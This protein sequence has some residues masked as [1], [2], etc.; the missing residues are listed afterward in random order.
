MLDR[1]EPRRAVTH[2]RLIVVA[3]L[4]SL[5]VRLSPTVET[6]RQR[7]SAGFDPLQGSLARSEPQPIYG[8]DPEDAWNQV[9][10]LLFTRTISARVMADGAQVFAAG[11]ERLLLSNRRVARIES[12]DRAID[13]LYPSWLWMG[14][15]A[16]DFDHSTRWRI[17]R[18]PQYSRLVTALE[19][20]RRT[21]PSRPPLARALMQADL[22]SAYDMLH[23]VTQRRQGPS[24]ADQAE[25]RAR[26]KSLLLHIAKTIRALALSA[27]EIARLPDTYSAAAKRLRLPD[28][29]GTGTGWMEIRWFPHRSH[30]DAA[31]HR[32]ATRVFFRPAE[33][34]NDASAFLNSFRT[35]QGEN[36]RS[37]DSVALL[38]QLL[39][40]SRAGIVVPSPITYHVQF[41][42]SAARARGAVIPQYEL[43]RRQLL[44]S[45][46]SGGLV[47]IAANAP[48][49]LPIAG[50]DFS[51][52]TSRRLDAEAVIAPLEQRCAV[53]HGSP[54]GVGHLMTFAQHTSPDK[55]VPP[56]DRLVTAHNVHGGDVARQKMES[57][58]FEALR[59]DWR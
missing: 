21:A 40:V 44:S 37:L 15:T 16:F 23:E 22:W 10:F 36:L 9:F 6:S 7:A 14:S 38:T 33:W 39:L 20:V 55:P 29:L 1:G 52:A 12:G 4:V 13:P 35:R 46:A 24:T 30:D 34:P 2:G 5:G 42:G 51:F 25:R 50:N 19:A 8:A 49:Y 54:A 11:D 3:I 26:T 17:L 28:I 57:E 47:G 59:E 43:S 41:R 53:C 18:E 48:A 31:G 32:R 58:K 45:A 27:E 56:V